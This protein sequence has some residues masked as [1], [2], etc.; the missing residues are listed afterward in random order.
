MPKSATPIKLATP[1]T[2]SAQSAIYTY[3][4]SHLYYVQT[5]LVSSELAANALLRTRP[6]AIAP[7]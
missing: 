7:G 1:I 2:T 3:L 4:E 5:G 6:R